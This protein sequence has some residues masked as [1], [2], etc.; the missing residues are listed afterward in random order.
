MSSATV[1]QIPSA[2]YLLALA[3]SLVGVQ[4]GIRLRR[5]GYP[6]V[7]H[8][9][10][11]NGSRN[12]SIKSKTDNIVKETIS[13]QNDEELGSVT[14]TVDK[15]QDHSAVDSSEKQNDF[16]I[17]FMSFISSTSGGFNG[18]DTIS[19]QPNNR[20]PCRS[21][22]SSQFTGYS[23]EGITGIHQPAVYIGECLFECL[24]LAAV[25]LCLLWWF[26]AQAQSMSP[27]APQFV[28]LYSV[29]LAA[30]SVGH[31]LVVPRT[32]IRV[33][34]WMLLESLYTVFVGA[35]VSVLSFLFRVIKLL[36]QRIVLWTKLNCFDKK[37]KKNIYRPKTHHFAQWFTS[38]S[39]SGSASSGEVGT[40][41]IYLNL[42]FALLAG[43]TPQARD[44][45]IETSTSSS[46]SSSSSS[47]WDSNLGLVY[48]NRRVVSQFDPGQ[49]HSRNVFL[50]DRNRSNIMT[51]SNHLMST[52]QKVPSR[53]DILAVD[54][55]SDVVEFQLGSSVFFTTDFAAYELI[56]NTSL[57]YVLSSSS[58]TNPSETYSSVQTYRTHSPYNIYPMYHSKHQQY[59]GNHY[60]NRAQL[61][62]LPSYLAPAFQG[63]LLLELQSL[64]PPSIPRYVE[65]TVDYSKN[66]RDW[67]Q[68][69]GDT[70]FHANSLAAGWAK[71]AWYGFN[72][73]G[74][75]EYLNYRIPLNPVD[76]A[77][78]TTG[79]ERKYIGKIHKLVCP[80]HDPNLISKE[81]REIAIWTP[82]LY[83]TTI[84]LIYMLIIRVLFV[85][86]WSLMGYAVAPG[87]KLRHLWK[88]ILWRWNTK[89]FQDR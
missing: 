45:L 39:G 43:F 77:S 42:F 88:Y 8:R 87:E 47:S 12:G 64:F 30:T 82:V 48:Q 6:A 67:Y 62:S 59:R 29:G 74:N 60:W 17:S 11:S 16:S 66:P 69:H 25:V 50:L 19:N 3:V 86:L 57:T 41:G 79:S 70:G 33:I 76:V 44:W 71:Q 78:S 51:G 65:S 40:W 15:K 84:I 58:S 37:T 36:F 53:T 5:V 61:I 63:L 2:H 24:W 7:H 28:L 18:L 49:N 22:D 85:V 73:I 14:G 52:H 56:G 80:F 21:S 38:G 27:W 34:C 68:S 83:Y 81:G 54:P 46:S 75:C 89:T 20:K 4:A 23:Y 55:S 9:G 13:V 35:S 31:A 72:S 32:D 10:S 26:R 1:T